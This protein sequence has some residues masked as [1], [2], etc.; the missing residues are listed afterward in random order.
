MPACARRRGCRIVLLASLALLAATRPAAADSLSV[1]TFNK[2]T[3]TAPVTQDVAHGLGETPKALIIWTM[4]KTSSTAGANARTGFGFSDTTTSRSVSFESNDAAMAAQA[5]RRM[6]DGIVTLVDESGTLRAEADLQSVDSTNF[7]LNWTTNNSTAYILHFIAIGGDHVQAKVVGWTM[8]T[9]TGN[10]SVTG[11]GFQPEVVIHT[12]VGSGHTASVP[13][14][15]ANGG[16]G[17]S[18]MDA[19][20]NQWGLSTFSTNGADPTDTSRFQLVD[21]SLVAVGGN[22][23]SGK[24]AAFVSMDSDGFTLNYTTA[25][26]NAGQVASLALKGV[27]AQVGNFTKAT[28]SAPASQSITGV[29]FKPRVLLLASV[30]DTARTAPVAHA[31]YGLGASDASSEQSVAT[32]DTDALF[33]TS[34]DGVDRTTKVF[35]KMNNDTATVDAEADLSSFDTAGFTLNW[36]TNDAV[37]TQIGYLA[38]STRRR[39]IVSDTPAADSIEEAATESPSSMSLARR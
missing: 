16:I 30:Q 12:H 5:Q 35:V 27:Q 32:S 8:R 21:K 19:L 9:S 7:T 14:T 17:L 4:G 38:L 33:T 11:V 3:G 34:V 25:N 15:S 39:V 36:T 10:Q 18:A 2:S 24:E 29:A 13:A 26:S 1:G 23:S 31:R 22:Q 37:A 20:G 6:S 28:G